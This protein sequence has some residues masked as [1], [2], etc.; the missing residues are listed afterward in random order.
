VPG[1][2]VE[3]VCWNAALRVGELQPTSKNDANTKLAITRSELDISPDASAKHRDYAPFD[4]KGE[5][6]SDIP[7]WTVT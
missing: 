5:A 7:S 2:P 4:T 3:G 6:A 1:D